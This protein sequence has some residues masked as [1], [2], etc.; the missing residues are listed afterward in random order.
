[1]TT[2][3][4][5]RLQPG[6]HV[7]WAFHDDEERL[8]TTLRFV[9]GGIT[10]GEK[11]LCLTEDPTP[12]A[13]RAVLE[14]RGVDVTAAVARGQVRFRDARG[15]SPDTG[16]FDPVSMLDDWRRELG[17]ARAEGYASLRAITDMAWLARPVSVTGIRRLAWYEA[18]ANRMF[19]DGYATVVC[20]Y[21]RRLFTAGDLRG[22]ASAHPGTAFTPGD[23]SWRPQLRILRTDDP[24]GLRLVGASDLS[25]R[26]ALTAVLAGAAEDL[27]GCGAP[28]TVDVTGLT[29]ADAAA[30]HALVRT[31]QTASAG[32]RIVGASSLMAKL[33]HLAGGCDTRGMTV[34]TTADGP[35]PSTAREHTV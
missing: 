28:L 19:A 14:A 34:E 2:A 30:V 11:V 17:R 18:Q 3:I 26:E 16:V 9:A 4:V 29:F 12:E 27:P 21:D 20:L 13:L 5:D 31:A 35:S 25:T 33:I 22:I 10:T 1:M 15:S 6:D 24:L 32:L 7:C 8:R 23:E